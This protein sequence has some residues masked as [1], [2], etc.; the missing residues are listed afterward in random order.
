M[1]SQLAIAG[2]LFLT[3]GALAAQQANP[4][5][6]GQQIFQTVCAMCHS[7][8]PP[9]KLAPPISHAAAY[10]MRRFPDPVPALLAY[11]KE[12]AA[13]RSAMPPHVIE[14]FG[15]MPPQ[16][17]LSDAQLTAVAR[18]ILTLADTVHVRARPGHHSHQR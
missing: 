14:R 17:H 6:E 8:A 1:R 3:T 4:P 7:V 18:Y 13:D 2:L 5:S 15:I 9:A 10:Y 11:L 16:S 12:P